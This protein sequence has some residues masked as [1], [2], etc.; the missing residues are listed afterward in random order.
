MSTMTEEQAESLRVLCAAIP[1]LTVHGVGI[2]DRA[3]Y[4]Y[5]CAKR[6][7]QK[8]IPKTHEG[9]AVKYVLCAVK[10]GGTK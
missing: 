1:Y 6:S 4:V 3:F 9:H 7:A 8:L 5:C 2:G 10:T